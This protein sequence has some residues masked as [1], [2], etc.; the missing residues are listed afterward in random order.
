MFRTNRSAALALTLMA[1]LAL[2]GCDRKTTDP[3]KPADPTTPVPTPRTSSDAGAKPGAVADAGHAE[4][5]IAWMKGDVDV[6]F[7]KAR[8]EN[9]P[10]FMYWG[11]VWCPPCN[12]VKATIFNR[13]DFIEQAKFFVPVY[14]D[15]DSPSAQAMGTRFKVS[16]YPTMV[17]FRPDGSEIVRLPGEVDGEKYMQVL[18]AGMAA[19]HPIEATLKTALAGGQLTPADWR[20]LAYYSF[21]TGNANLVPK[22]QVPATLRKLAANVPA[23]AAPDSAARLSLKA[24]AATASDKNDKQP[25]DVAQRE[26]ALTRLNG[27]LADPKA[28]RENFDLL[29]WYAGDIAPAVAPTGTPERAPLVAAWDKALRSL[30]NDA[31]L[32]AVDRIGATDARLQLATLDQKDDG[33]PQLPQALVDDVRTQAAA[34]DKAAKTGYERQAVISEAA[35]ILADAGLL[36]ESDAMLT[37]ELKRSHSPYYFMLGL[38]SNARKRGDVK[39]DIDWHQ[40][41]WDASEGGATR[42]QWGVS[43]V[44]TLLKYAPEDKPR[45]EATVTKI[46]AELDPVPATFNG[47]SERS[48]DVLGTRLTKWSTEQ[49]QPAVLKAAKAQ[50]DSVCAKLPKGDERTTCETA[51][52]PA[53]K[54]GAR[55]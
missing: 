25:L 31:S 40:K 24:L 51:F 54:D 23:D 30:A 47:R 34:A 35:G 15:G 2:A 7:A 28:A 49:K 16:G 6:A 29:V 26:Q 8:A 22:A 41:A 27:V 9:K 12:Q 38:A 10:V 13:Q 44:N 37:A 1:A 45:I 18:T 53:A 20:L 21:D 17:L 39:G 19:T 5:G 11:A 14:I 50:L 36:D 46:L 4:D 43:Y 3:V 52:K 42:L 48:I 33:K 55:A 32:S